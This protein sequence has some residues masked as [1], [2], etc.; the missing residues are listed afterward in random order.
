[1]R[2]RRRMTVALGV[3][4]AFFITTALWVASLWWCVQVDQFYWGGGSVTIVYSGYPIHIRSPIMNFVG[5]WREIKWLPSK[6]STIMSFDGTAGLFTVTSS[7]VP[8]A[9]A[10][11]VPDRLCRSIAS[12][13]EPP[14]WKLSPL[15]LI[16]HWQDVRR[17]SGVRDGDH[18]C[19][20]LV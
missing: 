8:L 14:A 12:H 18:F 3:L 10:I 4:G 20:C 5:S 6:A 16:P 15:R 7:T 11:G 17:V 9:S 1:M 19:R 13:W 2:S